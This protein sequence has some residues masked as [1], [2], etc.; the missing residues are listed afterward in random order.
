MNHGLFGGGG[1]SS[2]LSAVLYFGRDVMMHNIVKEKAT[3]RV[4]GEGGHIQGLQ[5]V[6]IPPG[7]GDLF[8]ILGEGDL[9]GGR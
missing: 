5:R 3:G 7:Y 8:K 9:S 6:W 4:G 2:K 1:G